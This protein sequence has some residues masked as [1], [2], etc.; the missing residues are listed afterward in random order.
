LVFAISRSTQQ[1][2]EIQDKYGMMTDR[3][4]CS[5]K[6]YSGSGVS[7]YPKNH[8]GVRTIY[9]SI[10][11]PNIFINFSRRINIFSSNYFVTF[12]ALAYFKSF[13]SLE[14]VND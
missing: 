12:I 9:K 10:V 14:S 8:L 11:T 2:E 5:K 13:L 6:A 1:N 3:D 7:T 4:E